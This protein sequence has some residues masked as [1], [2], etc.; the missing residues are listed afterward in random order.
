MDRD[1]L[2]IKDEEGQYLGHITE[3]L[4]V[5]TSHGPIGEGNVYPDM[6]AVM[7]DCLTG[8]GINMDKDIFWE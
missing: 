6:E 8:H 4:G 5:Y 1:V 3:M 2:F 7:R